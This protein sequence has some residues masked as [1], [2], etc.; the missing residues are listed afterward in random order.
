MLS[1]LMRMLVIVGIV[2]E[3]VV[4]VVVVVIIVVAVS[5]E[6]LHIVKVRAHFQ[7]HSRSRD[8]VVDWLKKL[9]T[10][11]AMV[12]SMAGAWCLVLGLVF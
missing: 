1:L 7:C 12:W 10:P 8:C 6:Y 3:V 2:V 9:I 5:R 4:A 11:M